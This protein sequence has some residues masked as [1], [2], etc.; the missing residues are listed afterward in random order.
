M[1]LHIRYLR[2]FCAA[3]Y[4]VKT[5]SFHNANYFE[6]YITISD[7]D[8][9]VLASAGTWFS[10][11]IASKK[12]NYQELSLVLDRSTA[13]AQIRNTDFSNLVIK[14]RITEI[15]LITEL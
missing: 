3:K 8:G 4:I 13:T 7:K 1:L 12:S 14:Y 10:G 6:G 11:V 15:Y 9:T 2:L 5:F